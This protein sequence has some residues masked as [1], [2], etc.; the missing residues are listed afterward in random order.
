MEN[1]NTRIYLAISGGVI[2]LLILIILV[3]F[4]KKNPTQN[5]K[6]IPTSQLFPTTIETN[7]SPSSNNNQQLDIDRL[8]PTPIVVEARFTGV[9][10]EE[11]PQT[12]IDFDAQKYELQQ[13][14]PL[15]LSTFSI[16]FDYGQDR[17]VVS[18]KDPKSQAQ[19]EFESWR[20][21]NYPKIGA[22]QFLLK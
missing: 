3:P 6:T 13:K 14:L 11:I 21:A 22:D 17:F 4:S 18:L 16:D 12:I 5:D 7:P 8:S 10:E 19:K 15:S 9:F 1:L 2:L 20:V